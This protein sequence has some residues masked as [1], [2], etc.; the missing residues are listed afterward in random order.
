MERDY[1]FGAGKDRGPDALGEG[2]FERS[3]HLNG[4]SV[5][6]DQVSICSPEY[7][8]EYEGGNRCSGAA[9]EG[10]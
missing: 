8:W 2:V 9:E 3:L 5:E 4:S 1:Y 7:G 10:K 6:V